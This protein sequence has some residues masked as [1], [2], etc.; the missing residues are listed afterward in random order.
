MKLYSFFRSSAS[1]RVRIALG[2]K[3]LAYEYQTVS[4]RGEQNTA[5]YRAINPQGLVPALDDN[6]HILVQSLAII[7]YLDELH[8]RP[9]LLPTT[10]LER[11]RVRGL[12]LAVACD[13]HPLNNLKVLNYI[14]GPMQQSEEVKLAWYRHWIAQG[15]GSLEAMLADHRDTGRFCHGDRP[16]LADICLVPQLYNARRYEC[17]LSS[18]PTLCRIDAACAEIPAFADARPERQPDAV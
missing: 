16:G 1:Y 9:P 2:L 13:I 10:A 5:A 8:P 12:A 3:G 6:G 14:G 18:Y 4:L 11:A 17:D 7:E 15:L